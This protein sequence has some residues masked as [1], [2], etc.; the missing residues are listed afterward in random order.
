MI[1]AR[2][3]NRTEPKARLGRFGP[4][5]DPTLALGRLALI[6]LC[7]WALALVALTRMPAASLSTASGL[8][9]PE[10]SPESFAWTSG[11]VAFPIRGGSGPTRLV[12]RL[13][14]GRWPGRQASQVT[15]ASDGGA[16][17]IFAAPD[18]ARTY[19]LLLPP[20]D[21]TLLLRATV[22]QP[23][24]RD[25][26]WL[27][28]QLLGLEAITTG[29]PIGAA[30]AALP[31]ALA[32]LPLALAVVWSIRRGYTMVAA[33]TGLGIVL[34]VVQLTRVPPGFFQDEA[35]SLVDAWHLAQTGRDHLGHF[36]P[37]GAL[38]AFGDWVSPLFTYLA[39]PV[40]A[41]FGPSLR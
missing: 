37:L 15:L 30:T 39:V 20:A 13:S 5:G 12:L 25:P 10:G 41:L 24:G 32:S 26:R 16:L 9:A 8:Y 35:I 31:I 4:I 6:G 36:L 3:E 2:S 27:G 11:E 40:V 7:V 14:A 23:P 1:S 18:Q 22:A 17:A 28:V 19:R 38:E 29:W 21:G 34:R 33:L